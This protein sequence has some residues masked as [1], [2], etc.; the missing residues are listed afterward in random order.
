MKRLMRVSLVLLPVVAVL[1]LGA[2]ASGSKHHGNILAMAAKGQIH[3]AKIVMH[4]T[5]ATV[6]K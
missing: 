2:R 4:I 3:P 1:V 6:R 5:R